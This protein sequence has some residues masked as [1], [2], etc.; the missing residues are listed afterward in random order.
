MY[1]RVPLPHVTILSVFEYDSHKNVHVPR[2]KRAKT[3]FQPPIDFIDTMS[4][5][6]TCTVQYRI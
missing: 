6:P 1:L 5:N 4:S 3:F 2:R